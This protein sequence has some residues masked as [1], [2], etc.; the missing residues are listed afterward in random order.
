MFND[1]TSAFALTVVICLAPI[2]LAGIVITPIILYVTSRRKPKP[3]ATTTGKPNTPDKPKQGNI[4]GNT[5]GRIFNFTR[6][7]FATLIVLAVLAMAFWWVFLLSTS[8][9]QAVDFAAQ[10]FQVEEET[11]EQIIYGETPTETPVETPTVTP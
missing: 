7:Y 5:V 8:D 10:S 3:S 6:I 2:L 4:V 9:E 11:V 1:L